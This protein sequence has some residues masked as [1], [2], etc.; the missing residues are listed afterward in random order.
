MTAEAVQTAFEKRRKVKPA[1]APVNGG[2]QSPP[3]RYRLM[4][5]TDL[6]S[7]PPLR[8]R[9]HSVLP[10][11][12]YAAIYGP[13]GSGK[14][15]VVVHMVAAIADGRECFGLRTKRARIVYVVLEGQA[16]IPKRIRAWEI[17]Q[18]RPFPE[19]VQFVFEPFR[20]TDPADV[21]TLAATIDAAGGAE[22]IVIDTLNRAAPTA[23]ENSSADMGRVFEAVK[24]LQTMTGGLVLLVHHSGKDAGRGMRGHSSVHAGLDAVIEV[25]RTGDRREWKIEKAKDDRDGQTFPFRLRVVEVGE[26]ED[27]DPITSCVIAEVDA[28]DIAEQAPRRP[29]H[30]GNQRIVF[31]AL[32]PLFRGSP[33]FGR[34]GA[35]A[36]RPC[37]T[38]EDAIEGTR[39]RLAVEPKR[40]AERARQAITG[41][42]AT[43]Y[44]GS[45][46]GWVWLK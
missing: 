32:G 3:R 28:G 45:N 15:F 20:L 5:S 11:S 38:L 22:V 39:E 34:S 4:R 24:E 25:S 23:D 12:G 18:G 1:A 46:E 9:I 41:L 19:D 33:H 43:G 13:S 21:L 29:P 37:L 2:P 17:E 14:G 6:G 7:L 27:G 31:D 8:W 44:L 42:I 40:R 30:G 26:D 10:D 36:I 16:G 35:P